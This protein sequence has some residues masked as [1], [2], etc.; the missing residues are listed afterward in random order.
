MTEAMTERVILEGILDRGKCIK[1]FAL[2]VAENAKFHSNP[3]KA[4]RFI[5]KNVL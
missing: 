4:D 5:A 3:Q 1:Q 2:I